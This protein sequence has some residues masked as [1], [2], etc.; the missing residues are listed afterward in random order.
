M[1]NESECCFENDPLLLRKRIESLSRE[2]NDC[3]RELKRLESNS[4][5]MERS[6]EN[7]ERE[8]DEKYHF[9]AQHIQ[10]VVYI[11][12]QNGRITFLI[13]NIQNLLG[14]SP[15]KMKTMN[16]V[17]LMEYFKVPE[18]Y[19]KLTFDKF[20]QAVENREPSV[21]YHYPIELNGEWRYFENQEQ[22]IYDS[23]GALLETI[24]V[25]RDVTERQK[26]IDAIRAEKMFSDM[27]IESLPGIFYM[28]DANFRPLRWNRNKARLLGLSDEEMKTHN[29]L[30]FIADSDKMK[31]VESFKKVMIEGEAEE[32]VRIIDHQGQQHAYLL[33]GKRLDTPG[34]P[35]LLGVGIDNSEQFRIQEEL[36]VAKEKAE[37]SDRLKS[38]FLNNISHEFRTPM[39]AILGFAELLCQSSASK[40]NCDFYAFRIRE[41]CMRLLDIVS[42][43]VE[44]SQIQSNPPPLMEHSVD[45]EEMIREIIDQFTLKADSKSLQLDFEIQSSEGKLMVKADRYKLFRSVKHLVHNAIKFTPQGFVKVGC[46]CDGKSLVISVKDNGVGISPE[47]QALIFQPFKQINALA[48]LNSSGNGI[49]L[50]LV[51]A[52]IELMNGRIE[53]ESEPGKGS[54]FSIY[55]PVEGKQLVPSM[56]NFNTQETKTIRKTILVVDDEEINF[57]YLESLLK[58]LGAEIRY[59]ANGQDA[60]SFLAEGLNVDLVLMDIRMPGLDGYQVTRRIKELYPRLPVIAQTAYIMRQELNRVIEG[61]FDDYIEKPIAKDQLL[62]VVSRFIV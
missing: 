14:I 6:S 46:Y 20:Y 21:N 5:G 26:A 4:C 24:G 15:E 11:L 8:S 33:T 1:S 43:I 12:D 32:I 36:K 7:S 31:L 41:S 9:I 22:L 25:I 42:D 3:K 59:A 61:G 30:N 47:M 39:N 40:E 45:I 17:E 23:S 18:E 53:L 29:T 38:A 28:F 34:G 58:P 49:G 44:I 35:L 57:L 56:P 37:E 19:K 54:V 50:A 62:R 52:Y 27:L 51:K 48:S 13:G 55:V 16:P 60:I 2:L 10:E